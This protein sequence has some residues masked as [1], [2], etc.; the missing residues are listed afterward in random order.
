[1]NEITQ[2]SSAR[3]ATLRLI[4][5]KKNAVSNFI[6]AGS[7]F[8]LIRDNKWWNDEGA[9]SFNSYIAET[10][11]DR[12]TAFK[13][14]LVFETFV[15]GKSVESI[16]QLLDTGWAKLSKVAPHINEHNYNS[17]LE[18]AES[19]SLSDIDQE[20]VRQGY[21]TKKEAEVLNVECPFCH[22]V[23]HPTKRAEETYSREDYNLI[24]KKYEELKETKF[25]GKEYD[26]IMQSIKTMFLN[27]RTPD[28]IIAAMEYAAEQD[29]VDWTIRTIQNKI[30]EYLPKL[31]LQPKEIKEEDRELLKGV[32]IE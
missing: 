31:N 8:K 9:E 25:E 23:F 32:G 29:Y 3:E 26:P 5:L 18:L 12:T 11:Y 13:M 28:Q 10:G 6:E 21:I 22:K 27:G 30:G 7:L 1:M 17:M 14:I 24:V 15:Q 20:L 4:E 16:Q 2:I 19:N